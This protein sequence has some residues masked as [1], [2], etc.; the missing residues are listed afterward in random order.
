MTST[1][2]RPALRLAAAAGVDRAAA[3][4][5]FLSQPDLAPTTRAKYRQTLAVEDELG[6][7][8]P[9]RRDHQIVRALL[10]AHPDP[11]DRRRHR[12]AA[13]RREARPHPQ[14]P[15]REPR[16]A[17]GA[18]RHRPA[19]THPLAA[20]LRD[21][22]PRRRDPAPRHRGPRHPR[23]ARP[24]ALEGR[25]CRPAVLRLGQRAAAATPDR[26]PPRRSGVPSQPSPEP[27]P[28]AGRR[29][30]LPAERP[31]ATVIPPAAELL[32]A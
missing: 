30:H 16:A 9:P 11:R 5:A 20:A 1:S 24:H 14:H 18:P 22:R 3:I 27:G 2:S 25:R 8:E 17:L 29:R 10:H 7:V 32:V 31:R 15:A 13:P 4:D 12:S 19:R 21:R 28:R 6:D 26:R 23:Q